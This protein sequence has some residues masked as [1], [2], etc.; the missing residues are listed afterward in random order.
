MYSLNEMTLENIND[1]IIMEDNEILSVIQLHKKLAF[2]VLITT[3]RGK[4][5]RK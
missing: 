4:I 3:E 1:I 2:I 5:R